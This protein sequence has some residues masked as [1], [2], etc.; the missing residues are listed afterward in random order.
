MKVSIKIAVMP[1]EFA[2]LID[3]YLLVV[4]KYNNIQNL[5]HI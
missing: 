4:D 5:L 2:R 3:H 1:I